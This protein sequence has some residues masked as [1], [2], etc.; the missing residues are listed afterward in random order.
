MDSGQMSDDSLDLAMDEDPPISFIRTSAAADFTLGDEIDDW[1]SRAKMSKI[2][3]ELHKYDIPAPISAQVMEDFTMD[4]DSP[5]VEPS[6]DATP[7]QGDVI[8]SED[9]LAHFSVSKPP[10]PRAISPCSSAYYPSSLSDAPMPF[11]DF[12]GEGSTA[13][14][15]LESVESDLSEELQA[16]PI[17]NTSPVET[18][19][20]RRRLEKPARRSTSSNISSSPPADD[21]PAE[22]VHKRPKPP[23]GILHS[24]MTG[25]RRLRPFG[26]SLP[27][28]LC[29]NT[30][31]EFEIPD[32]LSAVAAYEC[33][34]GFHCRTRPSDAWG[35]PLPD[36]VCTRK[37]APKE[38]RLPADIIRPTAPAQALA[39][40]PVVLL[41]QVTPKPRIPRTSVVGPVLRLDS[42]TGYLLKLGPPTVTGTVATPIPAAAPDRRWI[43]YIPPTYGGTPSGRG[44]TQRPV[45]SNPLRP[46]PPSPI[47][48]SVVPTVP[49][50]QNPNPHFF[51]FTSGVVLPPH[52]LRGDDDNA[53]APEFS[54]PAVVREPLPPPPVR[55]RRVPRASESM[56]ALPLTLL[57]HR[58]IPARVQRS[59]AFG[60]PLPPYL[61]R[62]E[63]SAP[64]TEYQIPDFLEAIAA[65]EMRTLV[66]GKGGER[67]HVRTRITDAFGVRLPEV[68]LRFQ[69]TPA[70]FELPGEV[71]VAGEREVEE[72]DEWI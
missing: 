37:Y 4:N 40:P 22:R 69:E 23:T 67:R 9:L 8:P 62:S 11:A 7:L 20:K 35:I 19:N 34:G 61:L 5:A 52:R 27:P 54:L 12:Q 25:P 63:L 36:E 66:P 13:G 29:D 3:V 72:K 38:F 53:E 41:K 55:P 10:S 68:L 21:A 70:I 56:S 18:P 43:P 58:S 48:N 71:F 30:A 42:P 6:T 28:I 59:S 1:A 51:A 32:F 64:Y 24:A 33:R 26:V 31:Y 65:F 45:H 44:R 14:R 46:P 50:R 15:V 16:D 39:P 2:V 17:A 49:P 47:N 60:A 57:P